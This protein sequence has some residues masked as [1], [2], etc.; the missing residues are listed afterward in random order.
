MCKFMKKIIILSTVFLNLLTTSCVSLLDKEPESEYSTSNFF[1][2]PEHIKAATMACYAQ[3]QSVMSTNFAYWG[4]GRADN[5]AIKHAGETT[6]LHDNNLNADL[7]TADWTAL[8]TLIS[9]C[10]YV[11]KYAP[12]VF[13]IGDKK[14][15]QYIGEAKA[16]RALAYFYLVRIW[17]DVP[18]IDEPYT[19]PDADLFVERT[20]KETVLDFVV[21]DLEYAV[22]NCA[23]SNDKTMFNQT[24][25]KGLLTQVFMWR[26]DYD[27]AIKY[28]TQVLQDSKYSLVNSMEEWGKMFSENNST[29]SIFE[30]GYDETRTN[31]LR[32]LYALGNDADYTPSIKFK[33]S[34]EVGDLRQEYIYDVTSDE[35]YIWKFLGKGVD[36]E[37]ST[38]SMQNI[39]LIRL[40]DI[41][42]LKAEALVQ[43]G[44]ENNIKEALNLLEPIRK[45]AG[46][47]PALLTQEKAISMYG[48]IEDAILHERSIEL[49]YEGH[50][51]F[52]LVRTGRAISTMQPIN[53]LSDPNNLVWPI[54]TNTINRNSNIIQN[55][56]YK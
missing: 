23:E 38:P 46:L 45:R 50:R 25:A 21:E 19:S 11:I 24:G 26:H 14:G 40:A 39:I 54:S 37:V 32:V 4:E 55:E 42:L 15:N 47:T 8:Y 51:W 22:V 35:T 48:T 27:N 36:D 52:D 10:N 56:Y 9:R 43:K 5:V 16:L 44:G 33:E 31:G 30:V 13:E 7:I 6:S 12:N 49:C 29:E 17:G 53:G 18:L 28:A 1:K 20:D 2:T 41:M 34:F 3:L